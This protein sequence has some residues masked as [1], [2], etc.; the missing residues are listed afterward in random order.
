MK[1][2][3]LATG[4]FV[5]IMMVQ[6]FMSSTALAK[7]YG[8]IKA[9]SIGT[10]P[11]GGVYYPIG[12][13]IADLL[14]KQ[15]GISTT[16]EVSGGSIYNAKMVHAK[17]MEM[18]I[19]TSE[20]AYSATKGV[21]RFNEPQD[22]KAITT[23]HPGMQHMVVLQSS[24]IRSV[25]DLKDKKVSVGPP[26]SGAHKTNELF[27]GALGLRFKDN[28]FLSPQFLSVGE[29]A[30]AFKNGTIDATLFASGIPAS[31]VLELETTHP[32]R[33]LSFS[34]EEMKK[35]LDQVPFFKRYV[36]PAGTYKSQ[37]TDT[38]T[39]ASWNLLTCRSD[40][41]VELVY[42]ITKAFYEN[43][44]DVHAIHSAARIYSLDNVKYI[45]IDIH[46]GALKY[47][48]EKG[49]ELPQ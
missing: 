17:K 43:L 30:E 8:N 45:N 6:L 42:D 36:I 29:S 33:L 22:L 26:G 39:F 35:I 34:D 21:G 10:A 47:Y 18:G 5:C 7:D 14:Q 28:S 4:V 16:A 11:V 48:K 25:G 41:P 20:V 19:M 37:K 24:D 1:K 44:D 3:S 23:L 2:I 12:A 49:V 27:M 40:L 32:I 38:Q 9:M 46:P 15:L 13:G 31:W